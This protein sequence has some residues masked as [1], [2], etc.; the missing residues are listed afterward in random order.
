MWDSAGTE[1]FQLDLTKLCPDKG[2]TLSEDELQELKARK[3]DLRVFALAY[4]PYD[5]AEKR[6]A[7][8][9]A[10]GW[11]RIWNA[12]TGQ[13]IEK[14][15]NRDGK[16]EGIVGAVAYSV[17]GDKIATGCSGG[18]QNSAVR[19]WDSKTGVLLQKST[20]TRTDGHGFNVKS[21][22]FAPAGD[23]LISGS[24]DFTAI[25]WKIDAS[26]RPVEVLEQK[27]RLGHRS[28][29][30]NSDEER[31]HTGTV[32]HVGFVYDGEEQPT[33]AITGSADSAIKIWELAGENSGCVPC[34]TIVLSGPA[35]CLSFW[36]RGDGSYDPERFIATSGKSVFKIDTSKKQCPTLCPHDLQQFVIFPDMRDEKWD[37]TKRCR[38]R[39]LGSRAEGSTAS[40]ID[41]SGC[42]LQRITRR[43]ETGLHEAIKTGNGEI[44]EIL[45]AARGGSTSA[46]LGMDFEGRTPWSIALA[47]YSL[48]SETLISMDYEQ[49][50][51]LARKH[52]ID[53]SAELLDTEKQLRDRL[54]PLSTINY[55]EE[56]DRQLHFE[57]CLSGVQCGV[58]PFLAAN[59]S[60]PTM[61]SIDLPDEEQPHAYAHTSMLQV[62]VNYADLK[63]EQKGFTV[64]NNH[65]ADALV[66]TQWRDYAFQAFNTDF[67]MYLAL[68]FCYTGAAC[69]SQTICDARAANHT[70]TG[71][72]ASRVSPETE[73]MIMNGANVV[74]FV[75]LLVFVGTLCKLMWAR[76]DIARSNN[77]NNCMT[78]CDQCKHIFA[79]RKLIFSW[80]WKKA[81]ALSYAFGLVSSFIHFLDVAFLDADWWAGT[82]ACATTAHEIHAIAGGLLWGCILF[83]LRGY[84][85][86][87]AAVPILNRIIFDVSPYFIV[88]GTILFGCA[89]IF[90]NL[91][92]RIKASLAHHV[93]DKYETAQSSLLYSFSMMMGG[94][95]ITDFVES[96]EST[97]VFVF[98]MVLVQLVMLNMLIAI[99]GDSVAQVQE[100]QHAAG[101]HSRAQLILACQE[102]GHKG[103]GSNKYNSNVRTFFPVP[104][105]LATNQWSGVLRE[106]KQQI[107]SLKESG[108][109]KLTEQSNELKKHTEVMQ[110]QMSKELEKQKEEMSTLLKEEMSTMLKELSSR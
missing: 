83:Y 47:K 36:P 30:P 87:E 59:L 78:Y 95:E 88:L 102:S 16:H 39:L 2:H 63:S 94:F 57:D 105:P 60:D 72:L 21:L 40:E 108:D 106:L 4:Q 76:G 8:G 43:G 97:V 107:T 11:V 46:V 53:P 18:P 99:M 5:N 77:D 64:F 7:S 10:D 22:A 33:K 13:F 58:F 28:F 41:H 15:G 25:V 68:V 1:R 54:K 90:M 69:M 101:L 109:A 86:T 37:R 75:L 73:L 61:R 48:S 62:L 70:M 52:D 103:Y 27:L 6:L 80:S 34:R 81:Q 91:Q 14:L 110:K 56:L 12:N 65:I 51:R 66:N 84:S 71:P 49:L 3:L 17:S 9:H 26:E 89:M 32:F 55:Y 96:G 24:E 104:E 85:H 45:C 35:S 29:P 79:M 23:L 19:V 44:A 31:G 20:Q 67:M 38:N 100:D 82:G 50:L 74:C 92:R 93:E 98:F 42:L